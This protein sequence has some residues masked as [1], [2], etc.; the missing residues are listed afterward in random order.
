MISCFTRGPLNT[1]L[2]DPILAV[3]EIVLSVMG[4]IDDPPS[5]RVRKL[6]MGHFRA[7]VLNDDDD[8]RVAETFLIWLPETSM[9]QLIVRHC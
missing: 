8:Q 6:P 4:C 3:R 1:D 7:E 5:I 2:F 9:D